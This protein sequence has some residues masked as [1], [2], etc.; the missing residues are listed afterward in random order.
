MGIVYSKQGN[1]EQAPFHHGRAQEVFVALYGDRHPHLANTYYNMACF[2]AKHDTEQCRM[3]LE[4]A[5]KTG[6]LWL[7]VTSEH[8]QNDSD[9]DPVRHFD[10]FT[11]M[12]SRR[13]L[14]EVELVQF[15]R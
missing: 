11:E 12:V 3:M 13:S 8:V 4:K 2:H 10:W 14:E 5:E 15:L 9:L 1:Y 6:C 7:A